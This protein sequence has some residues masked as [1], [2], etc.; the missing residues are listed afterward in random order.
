MINVQ[1]TGKGTSNRKRH[2]KRV[3]GR[4]RSTPRGDRKRHI[5]LK[6]RHIKL[7]FYVTP[8]TPRAYFVSPKLLRA[9]PRDS[10]QV[11]RMRVFSCKNYVALRKMSTP[12]SC[13]HCF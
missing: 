3:F 11:L 5:K 9:T 13:N 1:C 8:L 6:K 12:L 10:P 2:I 4:R 7:L